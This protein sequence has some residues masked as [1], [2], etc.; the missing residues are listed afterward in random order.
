MYFY[1]KY[2]WYFAELLLKILMIYFILL[3]TVI[4]FPRFVFYPGFIIQI[5]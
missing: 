5:L 3:D 1:I 2:V 4:P